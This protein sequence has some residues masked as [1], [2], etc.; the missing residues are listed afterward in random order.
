MRS[1]QLEGL[2][3]MVFCWYNRRNCILADEMGLGKTIQATS[4][5]EH[6]RQR[7]HIRGPF[8]VVA[9]LATLGNWKREIES[10]TSMNCVVYHDS[11][12]GAKT[13]AFIREHEFYYTQNDVY[14]RR[15]IY[16]VGHTHTHT[17]IYIYIYINII[18][19]VFC[20]C[21]FCSASRNGVVC[22]LYESL[23][24]KHVVSSM[25]RVSHVVPCVYVSASVSTCMK[26]QIVI[27]FVVVAAA[28]RLSCVYKRMMLLMVV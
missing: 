5:L 26:E 3:W 24:Y 6:L 17:H 7:E 8:L 28:N 21:V 11:E 1:Y 10:W 4:I 16:K 23:V 14:R 20:F 25:D 15:G 9:P 27:F 2:N 18:Q 22:F 19:R 12:G 13:R